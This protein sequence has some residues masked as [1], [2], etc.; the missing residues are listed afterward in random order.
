MMNPFMMGA[1]P[2]LSLGAQAEEKWSEKTK[3][4]K[5]EYLARKVGGN[6][7]EYAWMWVPLVATIGITTGVK[8]RDETGKINLTQS[9]VIETLVFRLLMMIPSPS[10]APFQGEEEL[11]PQ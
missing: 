11:P 6:V 2:N 10:L 4:E 9:G 1:G 7:K 3:Y 5:F 8:F